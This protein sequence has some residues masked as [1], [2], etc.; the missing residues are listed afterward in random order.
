MKFFP[1]NL[2]F[3][4]HLNPFSIINAILFII[5]KYS[6]YLYTWYN[7]HNKRRNCFAGDSMLKIAIVDDEKQSVDIIN[8]LVKEVCAENNIECKVEIFGDG[9]ALLEKYDNFHLIF[10]DIEM[11][12]IDGVS[13]AEKINELR[14][15]DIPFVV[16]VTNRDSMVFKALK[17][18]PYSFIRKSDLEDD[19]T[20]CII[21]VNEKIISK[22]KTVTIHS[23]RNDIIINVKDIIYLEKQKN[24]VIYHMAKQD[25]TVRSNIDTEYEKLEK[26]GFI[27]PH[28]GYIVNNEYI[29]SFSADRIIID[30]S[31][32]I[33]INKK[34]KNVKEDYFEWLGEK[35]V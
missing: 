7:K 21:K 2:L 34:Y 29:K 23:G 17:S 9:F 30:D 22:N 20:K 15:G 26:F 35:Y 10:L 33:P 8:R 16:F 28:I 25:Y 18:Y 14:S 6:I 27:R 5:V 4:P 11:P 31:T 32:F 19:L 24:Y 12:L 13:V 3:L 1:E